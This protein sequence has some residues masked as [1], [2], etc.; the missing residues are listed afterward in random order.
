MHSVAPAHGVA[1]EKLAMKARDY[2][3]S[4]RRGAHSN[5]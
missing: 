1:N 2:R 4:S 5:D 3:P